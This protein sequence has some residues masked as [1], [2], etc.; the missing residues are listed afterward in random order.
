VAGVRLTR[1]RRPPLDS[2]C[3]GCAT[4]STTTLR[5]R[6]EYL[7]G[8][9]TGQRDGTPW[10]T[11]PRSLRRTCLSRGGTPLVEQPAL[12]AAQAAEAG[13]CTIAT[14]PLTVDHWPLLLVG[15]ML[16]R[17]DPNGVTVFVVLS[18]PRDVTVDLYDGRSPATSTLLRTATMPA[19]K[20][21]AF[22]YTAAVTVTLPNGLQVGREYGYDVSFQL[23]GARDS[24]D[25]FD[26]NLSLD[27]LGLLSGTNP[28]GY[29]AS[30]LP[31]FALPPTDL[32]NLR[33]VHASCR[34]PS[35]EGPDALATLDEIIGM[36]I[37]DPLVRPH[38]LFLTGDQI[39]ADDVAPDLLWHAS[40]VGT[41]ALGWTERLPGVR[42]PGSVDVTDFLLAPTNRS[43]TL[44]GA[45][46]TSAN[47]DSHLVTLGEF[48]G[49]YMLVWSDALWQFDAQGKPELPD[50]QTVFSHGGW[51]ARPDDLARGRARLAETQRHL[52]ALVR[53]LKRVRRA[54]ANVPTYMIFDD[55][56]VADDWYID[57]DWKTKVEAHPLGSRLLTNALSAYAVFQAWGNEPAQFAA[58]TPGAKLLTR[59][60]QWQG[61]A[62]V[63]SQATALAEMRGVLKLPPERGTTQPIVW[64]YALDWHADYQVIA[65]DGRTE[66]GYPVSPDN[67]GASGILSQAALT[68]QLTNRFT[69][70]TKPLN[71]VIAPGPI[72]GVRWAEENVQLNYV[73]SRGREARLER[74]F[75]AWS[76]EPTTFQNVLRELAK[77]TRVVILSGDVH[78]GF[79]AGVD[80]WD[81]RPLAR[82]A[83]IVQLT[84]S[85]LKNQDFKTKTVGEGYA[86]MGL[87]SW[88]APIL[89]VVLYPFKGI[90]PFQSI[91]ATDASFLGWSSSGVNLRKG[92]IGV[93]VGT[94]RPGTPA[95]QEVPTSQADQILTPPEFRYRIRFAV[96]SR[97]DAQRLPAQAP[98]KPIPQTPQASYV[99]TIHELAVAHRS[100]ADYSQMRKAVGLN[101]IGDLTFTWTPASKLVRQALWFTFDEA[102]LPLPKPFTVHE[103]SLD[104]TTGAKPDLG[105]G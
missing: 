47:Q 29:A 86:W 38:Q 6:G 8:S 63:A 51:A 37:G 77:A 67:H 103:L 50:E 97:T 100:K 32:K 52:L 34:L 31:S 15:P 5:R 9:G 68:R 20:L 19:R 26:P 13:G 101:N 82:T 10:L 41:Q 7:S 24:K 33:L 104:P 84:A 87:F 70:T 59:L 64:D 35:A 74:D 62:Q 72:I 89:L 2:G 71:I 57:E 54:L 79:A 61:D 65:L 56:E 98:T 27:D 99:E 91:D 85:G 94:G 55:H 45:G 25:T 48:Y 22:L 21:G 69:A 76:F 81:E 40:S 88:V 73:K 44:G 14:W 4:P 78:Y 39:Y 53:E 23:T 92:G 42:D 58:G 83:R 80:Y 3:R 28:L 66:R 18:H 36:A 96:D 46:F 60:E 95:L 49:M 30:R 102:V 16:R 105:Q 17:V 43:A 90:S 1:L 93:R 75:E 12:D 11:A